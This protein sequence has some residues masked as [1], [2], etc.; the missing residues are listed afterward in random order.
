MEKV[1]VGNAANIVAACYH[2]VW[3][4]RQIYITWHCSASINRVTKS[5]LTIEKCRPTRD[6]K[7]TLALVSRF[8]SVRRKKSAAQSLDVI[9]ISSYR[10]I[11]DY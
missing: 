5:M 3:Q 7:T 8:V 9:G 10:P 6:I 1:T 2:K 4:F 11:L